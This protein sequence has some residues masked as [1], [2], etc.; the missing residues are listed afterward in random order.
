MKNACLSVFLFVSSLTLSAQI[1]PSIQPEKCTITRDQWGIPH[2][3]G[4]TDAEAAYALAWAH[5]ED[6]FEHIQ[7]NLIAG[8]GRLAEVLGKD[9]ALF[10][11]AMQFFRIDTLVE[12]RYFSDLSLEYRKMLNGYMQGINAYAAKHPD[13]VL[14]KSVLPFTEKDAVKSFTLSLTLFAGAGMAFKAINDNVVR[15]LYA[16]NETGS[17]AVAVHSNRTEDGKNWLLIN[18]HQP[19]EGRFAWYEAHIQS[20]EGW[21]ILGGLFPGGS[22]IFVGANE[23]LGWAHTTDYH[24]FGDIYELKVHKKNPDIYFYDN[25]WVPFVKR[26][27]K[28]KVKLAGIK[29]PVSKEILESAYG[30]VF[31][32]GDKYYA[33]RFPGAMDI[34]AGEQWYK[35]NKAKNF[36]EFHKALKMESIALFNVVYADKYDSIYMISAGIIPDRDSS[37]NWKQP[38]TGISSKHK[39]TTLL[40]FEKKVQYLNPKCGFIY[41]AN[42]TPIHATAPDE[43]WKDNFVGLQRFEYNRGERF[44]RLMN[45]IKGK[46][47]WDDFERIKY[48]VSYD[49]EGCY[50]DRFRHLYQLD[51]NKYPHLSTA[52]TLLQQ[53]DMRGNRDS[54][55]A[56]LAMITHKYLATKTSLPFA[57]L[58]IKEEPVSEAD[59]VEALENAQ[60]FL[61]KTHGS[62]DIPYSKVFRHI[63]GDVSLPVDGMS[64]VNSAADAKLV[65]KK[66]GI[67][68]LNG[69]DGYII[70]ARFSKGEVELNTINAYG[71]SSKPDSKHYTD[72]MQLFVD[73]KLKKMHLDMSKYD[74][75]TLTTYHPR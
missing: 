45:E 59:A 9:G 33:L 34:R 32:K 64:E 25:Q 49:P 24:N 58:M 38:V 57:Y 35:M 8:R 16:P 41:N 68:K 3:Y 2:V 74:A 67:Y 15:D 29:I 44:G 75:S 71:A 13:E 40:P 46:F 18:S 10:D 43:Y 17:N 54:R 6:D 7:H 27:A 53:W 42:N 60:K 5:A 73:Q 21:N 36:H 63:R 22:T 14:L 19:L 50:R 4:E 55:A 20:G 70:F 65:D 31:K 39:W 72:Q 1:F 61:K 66:K 56:A 26:K 23:H 37:L 51:S 30:P 48:D 12:S 52:I 47:T 11:F 62:V 28:L 69:G